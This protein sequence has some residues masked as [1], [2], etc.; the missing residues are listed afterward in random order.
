MLGTRGSGRALSMKNFPSIDLSASLDLSW[1][2]PQ[3]NPREHDIGFN[4]EDDIFQNSAVR[5]SSD[6]SQNMS[7]VQHETAMCGNHAQSEHL[8]VH[9]EPE[10]MITEAT[11]S[12]QTHYPSIDENFVKM[13]FAP[14]AFGFCSQA[15][16]DITPA[17]SNQSPS[18]HDHLLRQSQNSHSNGNETDTSANMEKGSYVLHHPVASSISQMQ[19]PVPLMAS[20]FHAMAEWAQEQEMMRALKNEDESV[21]STGRLANVS[22]L[23]KNDSM[24]H[25]VVQEPVLFINRM[26][27]VKLAA[28]P[29]RQ[30]HPI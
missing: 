12:T 22:I 28:V 29:P 24:P 25:K 21:T 2:D 9:M 27:P 1:L 30:Y 4:Q 5:V 13:H 20:G 18:W 8:K 23:G 7:P 14:Q 6:P 11:V 10:Q 15:G 26:N 19:L 3:P 16:Q 17:E